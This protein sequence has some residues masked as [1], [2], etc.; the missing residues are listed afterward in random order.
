MAFPVPNPTAPFWLKDAD[1]TLARHRSTADL[2]NQA[3]LVIVGSGLSAATT[4]H[5]VYLQAAEKG[6]PPPKVVMI[7]ARDTASGAT[8]RNGGHIKPDVYYS[9]SKYKSMYGAELANRL[10][11][12]EEGHVQIY[13]DLVESLG[14]RGAEADMVITQACDVFH[15]PSE[16]DFARRSFLER[17]RDHP[18]DTKQIVEI[19][20]PQE[21]LEESGIVGGKWGLTF[22]AGHIW[23][24][25]L[26]CALIQTSL[27]K[28]MNLQTRTVV[29][30]LKRSV[31]GIWRVETDRGT[32]SCR[33]VVAATNAYTSG[34]LPEI[35]KEKIVPVRGTACNIVPS[36]SFIESK[37]KKVGGAF[38]NTYGIR[39]KPGEADY[40]ISRQVK[41]KSIVLGGAKGEF[42]WDHSAWYDNVDDSKL[43]PGTQAY[44]ESYASKYF[45]G[46]KKEEEEEGKPGGVERVWTGILGYSSDLVPW[47]GE[48]D[49]EEN[50]GLFIIAGF[51]GHGMPRIPG[52]ASS[53]ALLITSK[54]SEG[55]V[56]ESV[57][58]AFR[59]SL[60]QPYVITSQRLQAKVNMI[61]GS[62]GQDPSEAKSNVHQPRRTTHSAHL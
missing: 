37:A 17:K 38:S 31:E 53:L 46:W 41:D 23:P 4:A 34:I 3:D 25:K 11:T 15:L 1:P 54:L 59:E 44:F 7:E 18:D 32:I 39:F 56:S 33:S 57:R 2:P 30:G 43:L 50:E 21:L 20:D 10:M 9:Y 6:L 45:K 14:E 26:C 55:R 51:H 19:T 5:N 36:K 29:V 61:K 22:P 60:P 12:Y 16:A 62:M 58:K 47:I 42:L 13:K 28:G 35:F 27:E 52:C 24:Y 49:G 48:L 40:M 8:G